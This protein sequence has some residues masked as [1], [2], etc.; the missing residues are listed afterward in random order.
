MFFVN[1]KYNEKKG[2]FVNE[3][4]SSKIKIVNEKRQESRNFIYHRIS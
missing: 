4:F 3:K 1:E 2:N